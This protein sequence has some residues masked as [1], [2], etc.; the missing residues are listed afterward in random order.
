[1]SK[2]AVAADHAGYEFKDALASYLREKGYDVIDLGTNS[3]DSVDYPVYAKKLCSSVLSGEC[4]KGILVC[5]T[6]IGMSIAANRHKGIRAALCTIPEYAR[7]AREHNNA[8]VLCLGARFVGFDEAVKITD[9]FL[10][11]EFLGGRHQNRVNQLDT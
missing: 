5:G 1:M 3:P 11:T 7:L 2:I 6:G 8:N 10:N 4:E 9:V